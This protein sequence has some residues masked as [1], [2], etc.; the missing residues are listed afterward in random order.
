MV[1]PPLIIQGE[2]SLS[3]AKLTWLKT[4]QPVVLVDL[5][6]LR[7][8]HSTSLQLLPREEAIIQS[9]APTQLFELPETDS[10]QTKETILEITP[11]SLEIPFIPIEQSTSHKPEAIPVESEPSPESGFPAELPVVP[12]QIREIQPPKFN[13]PKIALPSITVPQFVKPHI[14][15]S[16]LLNL[17]SHFFL[18]GAVALLLLFAGPILILESQPLISRA[19]ENFE[20]WNP[21][22]TKPIAQDPAAT[23]SPSPSIEPL[24]TSQEDVFSV[25]IPDLDIT[26]SVVANVDAND[27]KAYTTAL[28]KGIAHALGTGLPEQLEFSKTIY[29]FA[30]STDA[31]WNILRYNA[32]F[33]ALKDAEPG[34]EIS[35]TFWGKTYSYTIESKHIIEAQ[36]TSYMQPQM[37][38]EQLVLQTC[39]PPGTSEKRL[40][41]VATPSAQLN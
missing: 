13:F 34:Q 26:S 23:P 31:P 29:L 10:V 8:S 37:E 16:R 41:I 6:K 3:Q 2:L 36:D 32:Q 22:I 17:S 9:P 5:A 38:R 21:L 19:I 30:H 24:I 4:K 18:G 20:Q 40:I 28:K 14:E 27:S 25:S 1:D 33:Y 15:V 12:S 35:L 39:Y 7:K 11:Q